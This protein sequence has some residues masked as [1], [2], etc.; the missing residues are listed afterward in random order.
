VDQLSGEHIA[1][2]IVT[3]AAAGLALAPARHRGA[4][5][6]VPLSR[7]LALLILAAYLTEQSANALRGTWTVERSLP[8]HLTDAVTLVAV[9]ALW[10]WPLLL[11]ELTYFWGLSA[12]LQAV[13]TPDL[14]QAFPSVFYFTYFTTHAGVVV[15][16]ILLVFGLGIAPRRGAVGRVYLATVAFAALAAAGD[17]I[18]GGNYM[19]LREKPD[20][21]SLLDLM[22]PWPIY[23]A[24]AAVLALALY[25]LLDLPFRRSASKRFDLGHRAS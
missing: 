5:W 14:G 17:L 22:G 20:R 2:L 12:S 4:T 24:V 16:A 19:F 13:L 10:S 23:I 1:A 21:A 25:L 8:L 6:L 9:A 11:V 3:A 7:A 18:T 15:A